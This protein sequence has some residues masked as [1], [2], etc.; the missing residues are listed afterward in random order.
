MSYIDKYFTSMHL[1][2]MYTNLKIN[3]RRTIYSRNNSV[4]RP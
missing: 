1:T 3:F 4:T 2:A